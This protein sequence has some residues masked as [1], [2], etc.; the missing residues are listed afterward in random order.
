M[1]K[2]GLSENIACEIPY[3]IP[4][5]EL[6][7]SDYENAMLVLCN[8]INAIP[9]II[10]ISSICDFYLSDII[11]I[12]ISKLP[13]SSAAVVLRITKDKFEELTSNDEYLYDADKNT[14]DEVNTINNMLNKINTNKLN[15]LI[16]DELYDG[17]DFVLFAI[18]YANEKEELETLLDTDNPT[19]TLK[20]LSRLKEL[21]MLKPEH[22]NL[23]ITNITQPEIKEFVN[24]L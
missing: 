24:A 16:Y 7:D 2:S 18:D 23:A 5:Q 1:K 3:L 6:A 14:K 12:V 11:D 15:S 19:I 21:N 4:L 9:D 13:E 17:S 22:K 10:P 8:I 20:V